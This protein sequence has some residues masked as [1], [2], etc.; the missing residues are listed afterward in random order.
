MLTTNLESSNIRRGKKKK[1]KQENKT[2]QKINLKYGWVSE[3]F[4]QR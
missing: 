4:P 2:K 3:L 1:R